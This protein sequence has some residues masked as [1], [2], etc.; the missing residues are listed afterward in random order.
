MHE[1]DA[2]AHR[3]V[4]D[5]VVDR[6]ECG[7]EGKQ[8]RDHADDVVQ[9]RRDAAAG[10]E[11]EERQRQREHERQQR[12]G[13]HLAR[14]RADRDA[15]R[16]EGD[17]AG[18]DR[19]DPQRHAAVVQRHEGADPEQH[20]ERDEKRAAGRQ[21]DLA[22]QQPPARHEAARQ[23][24]ERVLLAL[25]RQQ[26]RGEQDA[27]EHQRHRDGERDGERVKRRAPAAE[28]RLGDLHRP[29]DRVEHV[30]DATDVR[31]ADAG[32]A[33]QR[34]ELAHDVARRLLERL[35]EQALGL[36]EAEQLE[37][38]AQRVDLA[39]VR[40]DLDVARGDLVDLPRQRGVGDRELGLDRRLDEVLLECVAVV[41]DLHG[42]RVEAAA[43]ELLDE[44]RRDDEPRER[45][46]RPH[47]VEQ[48]RAVLHLDALDRLEEPVRVGLDVDPLAA[49]VDLGLAGRDL[50]E[51]RQPRLL[52][53]AGEREP[54][55]QRDRHRVDHEQPDEQLGAP[56]DLQVLDEHP[57]H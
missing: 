33:L 40:D 55:Q 10:H 18:G 42:R 44:V 36:D 14:E 20:R 45:L 32:E 2:E 50:V 24:R 53:P 16:R 22:G 37:V 4:V 25:E 41:D 17:P 8:R 11:R 52:R 56:Q 51:E 46:P 39:A 5:R 43:G 1:R 3:R 26:A 27:D 47:L 9:Q 57:A 54:D 38:L 12:C 23:A 34:L 29:L 49:E 19:D 30:G 48:L 31:D 15:E 35:V 7:L 13:A 28:D 6:V 21:D